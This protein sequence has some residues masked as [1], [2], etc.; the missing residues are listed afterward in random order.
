MLLRAQERRSRGIR[1]GATVQSVRAATF[2]VNFPKNEAS[3]GK[4]SFDRFDSFL[5]EFSCELPRKIMLHRIPRNDVASARS[6]SYLLEASIYVQILSIRIKEKHRRQILKGLSR[7][8]MLPL[9]NERP[10]HLYC[11][12]SRQLHESIRCSVKFCDTYDFDTNF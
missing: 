3:Y 1:R 9:V 11:L 4:N 2:K 8:L 12:N 5:R 6:S 7:K 10:K